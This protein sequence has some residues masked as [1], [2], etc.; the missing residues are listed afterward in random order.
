MKM[1]YILIKSLDLLSISIKRMVIGFVFAGLLVCQSLAAE[2]ASGVDQID[3]TVI[4]P[5]ADWFR[6]DA[7]LEKRWK[8]VADPS[9][10]KR[11]KVVSGLN[12]ASSALRI[13]P[14]FR[15]MVLYPRPSSAYDL[16]ITKILNVFADR[17]IEAEFTIFNFDRTDVRGKEAIKLAEA[18]DID[19]IFTMGSESTAWLWGK[20]KD[21]K[22]PVVSVTSKDPVMLGQISD[23][24]VGTNSN[25]AFTSLNMPVSA[26]LAYVFE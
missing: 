21:G 8:F 18:S 11:L 2:Q 14:R 24:N 7:E 3:E 5:Y 20:Y 22:I 9:D 6:F 15:V 1:S 19:L 13:E 23:Y 26:Q 10:P 4:A 16:A 17:D 12:S 25:F